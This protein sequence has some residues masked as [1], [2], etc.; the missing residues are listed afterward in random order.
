MSLLRL[1]ALYLRLGALNE[2]QYRVNFFLQL[3][4]SLVAL[5]IGLV[6]LGLVFDHTTALAGWGRPELLAVMGVHI[7]MG[8]FIRSLIQPNMLRLMDDIQQGTLDFALT[9]PEDAQEVHAMIRDLLGKASPDLA[10]A[11]RI[12][13]GGSVKAENAAGL[14]SQAD[15]DGALVGG[16]SLDAAGF[17]QIVKAAQ[18]LAE[19]AEE[20]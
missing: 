7:L 15:V 4:E 10:Q 13:Y 9:K 11:T 12:L 6:G 8:G 14:L 19:R 20:S 2:L 3:L 5:G 16:A 18:E 17:T 1:A